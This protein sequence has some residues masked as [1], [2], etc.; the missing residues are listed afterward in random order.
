MYQVL[1]DLVLLE[2]GTLIR[3][4]VGKYFIKGT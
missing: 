4:F 1:Q 2:D 3:P